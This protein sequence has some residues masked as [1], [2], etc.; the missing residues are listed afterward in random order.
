MCTVFVS[1]YIHSKAGV[2]TFN[3]GVDDAN[4]HDAFEL[5]HGASSQDSARQRPSLSIDPEHYAISNSANSNNDGVQFSPK[6]D[7]ATAALL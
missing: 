3:D 4:N 1:A 5:Q 7:D 6:V 2:I